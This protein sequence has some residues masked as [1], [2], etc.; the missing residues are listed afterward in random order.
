MFIPGPSHPGKVNSVSVPMPLPCPS[1]AS[2]VT[3]PVV[4][5]CRGSCAWDSQ[6]ALERNPMGT[7]LSTALSSCVFWF[8]IPAMSPDA[9]AG[10]EWLCSKTKGGCTLQTTSYPLGNCL[11]CSICIRWDHLLGRCF[12]SAFY[13]LCCLPG[14]RGRLRAVGSAAVSPWPRALLL[15]AGQSLA[16]FRRCKC[17]LSDGSSEQRPHFVCPISPG[18]RRDGGFAPGVWGQCWRCFGERPDPAGLRGRRG[19][20]EHRG[21]AV[22]E[23]GQG[24]GATLLQG[25][26]ELLHLPSGLGRSCRQH[27]EQLL[28]NFLQEMKPGSC[29][30]CCLFFYNVVGLKPHIDTDSWESVI[31]VWNSGLRYELPCDL[32]RDVLEQS[33][34]LTRL[35]WP[36]YFFSIKHSLNTSL[37]HIFQTFSSDLS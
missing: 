10:L 12:C 7:G 15:C 16:D 5:K 33:L 2:G 29:F 9:A 37:R 26:A 31:G 20:P 13:V 4:A 25:W 6:T 27:M 35:K 24:K 32:Q 17:E 11:N 28:G 14:A 1:P 3:F 19:V 34:N 36:R 18:I 30:W 22:Q 8:F 23:T 21:A